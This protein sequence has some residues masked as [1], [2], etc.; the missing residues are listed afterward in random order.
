MKVSNRIHLLYD[1]YGNKEVSIQQET[2]RYFTK[3]FEGEKN[4]KD[5]FSQ[6]V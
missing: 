4:N 6:F 5:A 2:L 3:Y 1:G